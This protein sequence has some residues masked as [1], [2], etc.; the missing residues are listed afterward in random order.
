MGCD[1]SNNAGAMVIKE[2]DI[3]KKDIYIITLVIVLLLMVL[4]VLGVFGQT[5]NA[6]EHVAV[7]VTLTAGQTATM[8]EA[9]GKDWSIWLHEELRQATRNHLNTARERI[10]LRRAALIESPEIESAEQKTILDKLDEVKAREIEKRK[11]TED[12]LKA[13]ESPTKGY[14]SPIQRDNLVTWLSPKQWDNLVA[15][16]TRVNGLPMDHMDGWTMRQDLRKLEQ[17]LVGK[18]NASLITIEDPEVSKPP[19]A[20]GKAAHAIGLYDVPSWVP[21]AVWGMAVV[22]TMAVIAWVLR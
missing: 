9:H 7:A 16:Y 8:E 11:A 1:V 5:A 20:W 19:N 14:S 2:I 22:G 4:G 17:L 21:W 6:Q 3:M 10:R 13:L 15:L 12:S 18:S